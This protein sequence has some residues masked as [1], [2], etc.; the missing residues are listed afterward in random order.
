VEQEHLIQQFIASLSHEF[1]TPLS[2]LQASL[3]LFSEE[4]DHLSRQE[5]RELLKSLRLSVTNLQTLVDNLLDSASIQTG[6]LHPKRQPESLN[7]IVLGVVQIMQPLLDRRSQTLTY[8]APLQLQPVLVDA[9]LMRQ[10]FINLL[11]NASKYSPQGTQIDI[12]VA[13]TSDETYMTIADRGYGV[14]EGMHSRIF[15]QF[16][17]FSPD[18][19]EQA[20]LGLGLSVVKAIIEA[21]QGQVGAEPRSGGGSIFWFT[22]Q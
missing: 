14:P 5:I 12:K 7:T 16:R 10:V 18:D 21:H 17:R 13:Q 20:G 22:L 15:E 2:S 19:H 3:E 4:A 11:M 8:H 6:Q 9:L 1:R